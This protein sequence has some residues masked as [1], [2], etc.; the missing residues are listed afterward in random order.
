VEIVIRSAVLF[1]AIWV[2][3][4]VVGKREMSDLTA[5]DLVLLVV[6][7]DLIQQGVTQEDMS[8]TGAFMAVAT[9]GLLMVVTAWISFRFKA[10]RPLLEGVPVVIVHDGEPYEE[11]LR[12]ERLTI[13]DVHEAARRN[14]V[15]DLK[16]VEWAVL[17]PDG[18]FSFLTKQS[19]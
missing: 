17:E 10:T 9:I 13:N 4:R 8:V 2:L 5:F 1:I 3:L 14:G 11:V 19:S 7:G 12:N 6:M 18:K 15:S 16:D